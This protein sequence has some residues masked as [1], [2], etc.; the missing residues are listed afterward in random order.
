MR[1]KPL[2]ALVGALIIVLVGCSDATGPSA[3]A[4]IEVLLTDAPGDYLEE[5]WICV[6]AVYLQGGDDEG[7]PRT[8]LWEKDTDDQC[9]DLL[10]L[11]GV[12]VSLTG[13]LGDVPEGTYHQLRIVVESA[14]VKLAAQYTVSGGEEAS[15]MEL[16]VPSGAQTGIKVLLLGPVSA[17]ADETTRITVDANVEDNFHIQGN[18]ESPAGIMGVLFT[19]VLVQVSAPV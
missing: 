9:F 6:A 10:Q 14:S 13:G 1:R 2:T 8:V 12:S 15:T 4:R 11:Q 18:P 16:T 17:D 3:G 19:P 5:A 7:D